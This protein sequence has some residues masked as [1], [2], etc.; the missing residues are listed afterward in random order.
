MQPLQIKADHPDDLIFRYEPEAYPRIRSHIGVSRY[1]S[2]IFHQVRISMGVLGEPGSLLICL[3]AAVGGKRMVDGDTGSSQEKLLAEG[4]ADSHLLCI[5]FL[6]VSDAC[7]GGE[8][9]FRKDRTLHA[10]HQLLFAARRSS[11]VPVETFCFEH[12]PATMVNIVISRTG[13][14]RTGEIFPAPA[15]LIGVQSPEDAVSG[16][17]HRKDKLQYLRHKLFEIERS[18]HKP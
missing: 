4:I 10:F 14:F 16:I 2:G 13:G 5:R 17:H 9:R 18:G 1:A 15:Y 11:G 7:L 8:G 3:H 6:L 12:G